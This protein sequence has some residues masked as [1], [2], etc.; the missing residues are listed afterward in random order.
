MMERN[1]R[2][3]L[4]L[5][6][7]TLSKYQE[8]AK[9][10]LESRH[11]GIEASILPFREAIKQLDEQQRELEKKRVGSY[12]ALSQQIEGMVGSEKDLRKEVSQLVQALRSPQMRGSWGE[13]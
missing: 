11:K 4:D 12:A 3:F 5:A 10:D 13:I 1:S 6:H 8:S 7:S 9:S 2:T